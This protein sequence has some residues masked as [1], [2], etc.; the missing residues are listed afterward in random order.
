MI[1]RAMVLCPDNL[2]EEIP[3]SLL[4]SDITTPNTSDLLDFNP[5]LPYKTV[6][7]QALDK[8]ERQYFMHLLKKN[9]GSVGLT[10]NNA[11]IDARTVLRKMKQFGLNRSDFKKVSE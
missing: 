2:I 10:A 3:F 7:D 8:I 1:Q 5:N 9:R 4:P 11:Q 6:R